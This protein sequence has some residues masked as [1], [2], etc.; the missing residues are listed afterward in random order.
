MACTFRSVLLAHQFK[1]SVL[2]D[3]DALK[4]VFTSIVAG[5][6]IILT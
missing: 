2:I 1:D 4:Q 3:C 6:N 5:I